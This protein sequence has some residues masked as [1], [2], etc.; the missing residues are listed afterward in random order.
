MGF[1]ELGNYSLSYDLQL[2]PN[3]FK[4]A[5]EL[6]SKHPDTPIIIGHLGSPT[7]TDLKEQ[8]QQYWDGLRALAEH[9]RAFIKISMLAYI[10]EN[11]DQNSL[12]KDTVLRVIDIFGVDRCFF[13]SNFPAEYG[14]AANWRDA[15]RLFKALEQL[16]EGQYGSEE[17]QK[18]FSSTAQSVYLPQAS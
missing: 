16:V 8:A 10:D 13:A 1:A 7:Q 14:I 11:W 9:E 6:I 2:N 3:Q 18:L 15:G 4:M 12:I 17:L 5:A